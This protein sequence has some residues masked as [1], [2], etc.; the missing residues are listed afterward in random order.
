[1]HKNY[2]GEFQ[3]KIVT[4]TRWIFHLE[5]TKGCEKTI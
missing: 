3:K 4:A 2:I 1:M 5:R